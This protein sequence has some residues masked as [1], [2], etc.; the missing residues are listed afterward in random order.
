MPKLNPTSFESDHF[1]IEQ[2]G[3]GVYA[4]IATPG[5]AAISN[6]GIIDLGG[7]TLVFDS[8][9]T[10]Q[11]G[12]DLYAAARQLTG[13][14]PDVLI[15]SHYH[16]DHIW[17]NQAFGPETLVLATEHTYNL[18]QTAGRDEIEWADDVAPERLADARQQYAAAQ[19]DSQRQ[20]ALLWIGYF[21]GLVKALPDLNVRFPDLTFQD[22]MSLHGSSR[23]VEL[24]SFENCHAGSDSILWLPDSGILF[25]ADLLFV[26]SHPYLD[27]SD[28]SELRRRLGEI[29]GMG[30]T[31]YVP[32]H[33]PLG[34]AQD[35]ASNLRYIDM[36]EAAARDLVARGDLSDE[37][38]ARQ[39]PSGEFAHWSLARFY[40]A[41]LESLCAKIT[42]GQPPA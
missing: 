18:M 12:H 20:D 10:P 34:S 1:T 26:N 15:N 31:T 27:E 30:A 22:R 23:S 33:G 19:E 28:I 11:A 25:M 7:R 14:I 32:G 13:R 39:R 21:G 2:L 35:I 9:M 5:G 3:D 6:A 37:T 38:L 17:G 41:N 29:S 36:C 8:F 4:A 40:N 24:I 42:A 16:N